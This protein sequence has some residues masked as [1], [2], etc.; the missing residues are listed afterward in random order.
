MPTIDESTNILVVDDNPANLRI[1]SQIL[2]ERGYRVRAVTS[3]GRALA[4]V[5]LTPPDLILLDIRMPD[6]DGYAVC[7]QLKATPET[8]DIPILFI[9]ALDDV[10]DKMKAF[11]AGGVDYITKPFQLEEVM[12]RV[13]THLSLR[14]LRRNLQAAHDRMAQE[15]ALAAQVQASFMHR[16]MP[17]IPGWQ[18]AV[19]LVPTRLTSGDFYDTLL[20]PDG[21]VW[22]LIADVMDKGV[23]AA[24]YMAMSSALLRAYALEHPNRPEL[25]CQAVNARLL[26]YTTAD[27]FVTV[28]LGMLDPVT[29][30][31]VYANAGHNP[32]LLIGSSGSAAPELLKRTGAPLGMLE[33]AAWRPQ[34]VQLQP[35][36]C[37]VLYTDG[38]TEAASAGDESFGLERLQHVVEEQAG[39][40]A[41]VVREAILAAVREFTA[42]VQL[43]DDIALVVLVRD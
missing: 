24:L 17:Q 35:G 26:E 34:K 30:T 37:L 42:G 25:V 20:L 41:T 11:A 2:T 29:N 23:G 12:A 18:L 32:P 28:F 15:L 27:Q 21:S 9:S 6:M 3:G 33:E 16:T 38:V 43:V 8:A 4:S 39:Q 14:Q 36:D 40:P 31:L 13:E 1:L 19:A 22:L 5:E 10:Q 7:K